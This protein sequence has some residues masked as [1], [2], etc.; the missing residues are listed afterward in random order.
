MKIESPSVIVNQGDQV[1]SLVGPEAQEA[2][3]LRTI[4]VGLKAESQGIQLT[5]G[6]SALR[7]A[8]EVTGLRTNNRETQAARV[9]LLLD[10]QIGK[11]IVIEEGEDHG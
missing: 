7:L 4:L 11:C 5:K 10:L 6:V 2:M 1:K 9:Q 3:R 8:K